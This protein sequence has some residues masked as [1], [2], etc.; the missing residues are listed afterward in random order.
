MCYVIAKKHNQ[1]GCIAF[2]IERSRALAE[3]VSD[4]G[5]KV[6]DKDIQILTLTDPDTFGEYK[7]YQMVA[8]ESEF[9][10]K[11]LGGECLEKGL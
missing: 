4:L 7:P 1:L 11:V 10:S 3:F 9:V 6:L 2:K 5:W 8:T